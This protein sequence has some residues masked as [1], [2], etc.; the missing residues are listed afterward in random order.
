[1]AAVSTN[2]IRDASIKRELIAATCLLLSRRAAMAN[3]ASLN[4]ELA[5]YVEDALSEMFQ[6]AQSTFV[7]V[8]QIIDL[9]R[10]CGVVDWVPNWRP[11]PTKSLPVFYCFVN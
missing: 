10:K 4:F 9:Q 2:H 3:V 8:V 6:M 5:G 11:L 7:V 1:M